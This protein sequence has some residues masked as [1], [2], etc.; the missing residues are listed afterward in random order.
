MGSEADACVQPLHALP[1]LETIFVAEVKKT[2]AF[3][4]GF[5]FEAIQQ[6][7]SAS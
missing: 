4:P 7:A 2:V 5:L 6:D 3:P 1:H